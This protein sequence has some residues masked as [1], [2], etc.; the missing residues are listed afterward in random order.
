MS[1]QY[2]TPAGRTALARH[3]DECEVL[4]LQLSGSKEWRV[5]EPAVLLPRDTEQR[6]SADELDALALRPHHVNGSDGCV[7]LSQCTCVL[8]PTF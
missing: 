4:V 1:L 5:F 8:L 7:T 2:Y 3:Y 6:L